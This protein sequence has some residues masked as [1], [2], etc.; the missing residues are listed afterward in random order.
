MASAECP[1]DDEDLEECEPS[2]G[3]CLSPLP[4]PGPCDRCCWGGGRLFATWP[5]PRVSC[6]LYSLLQSLCNLEDPRSL[7]CPLTRRLLVV[8]SL[9]IVKSLAWAPRG[10]EPRG[11]GRKEGD[12]AIELQLPG[13]LKWE[14]GNYNSHKASGP[15]LQLPSA[16]KPGALLATHRGLCSHFLGLLLSL[17]DS[18]GILEGVPMIPGQAGQLLY[19]TFISGSALGGGAP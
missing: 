6:R 4:C 5:Q 19:D 10:G 8:P 14:V 9:E 12:V 3:E 13:V 17:S 2:T 7:T 16:L 15:E 18:S 11:T 1:S